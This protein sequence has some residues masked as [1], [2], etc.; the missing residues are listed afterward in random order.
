[1]NTSIFD[2]RLHRFD[3]YLSRMP[4]RRVLWLIVNVLAHGTITNIPQ[5]QNLRIEFLAKRTTAILQ[6]L[7]LGVVA[8]IRKG[9]KQKVA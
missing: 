3:T 7:D 6:P 2:R 4:G 1:M 8:C 5:L 9:Y